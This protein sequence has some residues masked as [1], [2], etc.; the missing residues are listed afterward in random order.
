MKVKAEILRTYQ[1]VHT[2]TG[3]CAGL[4]L[5]IGFYAGSLT[6]FKHQLQAWIAPIPAELA[7]ATAVPPQQLIDKAIA[8]YPQAM[9]KGFEL[10]IAHEVPYLSWYSQGG[11]RGM[12][13]D[14]QL[15]Y[16]FLNE[17]GELTTH[18]AGENKFAD[19][20]D[21]LHRS[22][23]LFGEIG[24]DQLGVYVLGIAALL[25]F[26]ALVS[27]VVILLPT[28]TK[29]FFALRK[30]K[31]ASRLWLDSHNLVG[32]VSLPF[33]IVIA[34]SVFVFA[35]HDFLYDGLGKFYGDKPL[36]NMPPKTEQP[37]H[38]ND[39]PKLELLLEKAHAYSGQHTTVHVSY[40][41]L[42]S[43]AP[44][45][46]LKMENPSALVRGPDTDYLFM[47]PY[48]L[49][50][51][52][53]SFPQGVTGTWGN[54]VATFFS[55]HFGTYGGNWGRWGYFLMGLLGAFLFYSGN[56]LWLDKRTRKDGEQKRSTLFM[57]KLTIGV[58]LGSML[59]VVVT[60][61]LGK[62]L[63]QSAFALNELYLWIYYLTFGAF[64]G[65]SFW[66]GARKASVFGLKALALGCL[67]LPLATM[68]VQYTN[69]YAVS[70]L[71]SIWVD[72]FG[73]VFAG[74]FLFAASKTKRRSQS[75]EASSIWS[76]QV[77]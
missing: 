71:D 67:G 49:D 10:D 69:P 75:R 60:L 74:I 59:G 54:T 20:I 1:S 5:F 32:I 19:L 3:I 46:T 77:A 13:L 21:Y 17:H 16:A 11:A 65:L 64:I 24:H 57:A 7:A 8:A 34:F 12:N 70:W 26:L 35:Y 66:L 6:M 15:T 36:F 56:L 55:L 44:F 47:H 33:H 37:Y 62:A 51:Q 61:V 27:G 4:L 39:L 58:C 29:T 50:V 28:L 48:T 52:N 2:W 9:A 22:G 30:E 41:R 73:V 31:G 43:P 53:S 40:N 45:A 72:V 68:F 18:V 38:I 25:Y 76:M 14:N 42:N 63:Q 23:G